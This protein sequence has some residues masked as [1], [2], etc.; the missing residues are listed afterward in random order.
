MHAVQVSTTL[1]AVKRFV[2]TKERS[3]F[4]FDIVGGSDSQFGA[5]FVHRISDNSPA[6][7]AGLQP[8][9]RVL[10]LDGLS[11]LSAGHDDAVSLMRGTG[12]TLEL[13]CMRLGHV[14]WTALVEEVNGR[15]AARVAAMLGDVTPWCRDMMMPLLPLDGHTTSRMHFTSGSLAEFTV[16]S[17][18]AAPGLGLGLVGGSDTAYGAVLVSTVTKGGAADKHGAMRIGDRLLAIN[19][20]NVLFATR[21]EVAG[22]IAAG[23]QDGVT[24]SVLHGDAEQYFSIRNDIRMG[25]LSRTPTIGTKTGGGTPNLTP[26]SRVEL[27]C[28]KPTVW[29]F[30][31]HSVV[32]VSMS[33]CAATCL[34]KPSPPFFVG[35]VVAA[36]LLT[37]TASTCTRR[38]VR[39]DPHQAH[40]AVQLWH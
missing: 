33:L 21:K 36:G 20:R 6:Q 2:L 22:M 10:F 27:A 8:G 38:H 29:L 23:S 9:D 5:V 16:M 32:I 24:F 17:S 18:A 31:P 11:L 15:S 13:V 25:T 1:G 19:G 26:T 39:R 7:R 37:A 30:A 28:P 3:E 34:A 4:G 14:Q 40:A 12:P 35:V